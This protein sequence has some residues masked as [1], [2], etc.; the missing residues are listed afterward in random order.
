[1][2]GESKKPGGQIMTEPKIRRDEEGHPRYFSFEPAAAPATLAAPRGIAAL[3][4]TSAQES[5]RNFLASHSD[6]LGLA[7]EG[8]GNLHLSAAAAP[9]GEGQALRFESEK[10]MM[11]TSTVTYVQTMFGLPIYQA[12]VSVTTDGPENAVR[13]AS[14]T[15]HY[16]VKAKAPETGVASFAGGA[17]GV[18]NG[19]YDDLVRKALG[20]NGPKLRINQVRLIVYLYEADKRLDPHPHDK[21]E[22]GFGG[23]PPTLPLPPVPPTIKD[24]THYIVVEAL[25]TLA[26]PA[27]GA[28]NWRAFIEVETGAVLFLRALVD[29]VTGKVFDRD[30]ITKTGLAA[31]LPNA[32][33]ATL[34]GV[35]DAVSLANLQ[36]PLAGVQ[37]LTGNFVRLA[38]N[39]APVVAAPTTM[40]PFD[41]DYGSRTNNFGAANAYYHCDRFFQMVN[42][43]G[44]SI[45]TYFDGTAFPVPVDHHGLGDVINANCTGDSLGDGIGQVNFSLADTGDIVHPICIGADWR[46]VLHELG[47]HGILWDHVS[48][49]NFGFSHSAGDGIAAIVNDPGSAAPDRFV[50]FPWVNI[51]RRHDRPVNGW[52]W[53]GANDVG[54]YSSEQILATCH[55]RIYRSIGGDAA[56]L[57]QKQFASRS[58]VY[59]ILRGV[60][61]LT[62]ATN[63]PTPLAWEGQLET[64]DQ[65]IW[66]STNP[67]ET[68]AGG[69]YHKVIRWAFEKQGLFRAAGDPA[70]VEGKPPA[71]DVFI[72][73]G[74]HGEYPYQPN[75]WSCTDIWNRRTVGAGGGVHEE[76]V[77]GQTNFAYVRIKNRGTQAA[78]N[79][80]VK[81]FHCLPGVGLVFPTDWLPM[82]T[83]QLAGPNLAAGDMAGQVVGPFQWV[84]SQVGHECMFFSVSAMGDAGNIDGHVVG[85]IPE[86]R[87]VPHD[88]NIGQ[89]NVHPVAPFFQGDK[90]T[91]NLEALPFWIRN[92]SHKAVAVTAEV[93]LPAW[94]DKLGWK[95]EI[96]EVTKRLVVKPDTLAKVAL[97]TAKAG[98]PFAAADLAKQRDRDIVVTVLQDG[99]AVGGMTFQLAP[100]AKVST[101]PSKPPAQPGKPNG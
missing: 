30:P 53:G 72:D 18:S 67:A 29:G 11:G 27:W 32:T 52:G 62:P 82:A 75:H 49:P 96:P 38:E 41:F 45:A 79:V 6:A 43:L 87:L 101:Q 48:S 90:V 68:Q 55:F 74:R 59:L 2:L 12:G 34:D 99:I 51:G 81:G 5:A 3:T 17:P 56:T 80:V 54:G 10:S 60:G 83:P 44:F 92:R 16:D 4:G 97:A 98:K 40:T 69:A 33:A 65:G 7:P 22:T 35:K 66:I 20:D 42:D 77:V 57:A 15:L 14:S 24:G 9:S 70:T 89:R 61:Q 95:L 84:P 23:E 58:M 31:N 1:M 78:N 100:P 88:N 26:V 73:D 93:R 86:W 39:L 63:P 13:A 19:G 28:M 64:A 91:L 94:L 47:G 76:P 36:P 37:S 50:T 46:V 8:M 71:V 85:P 21:E 25:F